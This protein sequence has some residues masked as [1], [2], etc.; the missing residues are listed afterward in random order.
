[1]IYQF[2]TDHEH[3]GIAALLLYAAWRSRDPSRFKITPDVWSQV[4]SFVKASAKRASTLPEFLNSLMPRLRA[5]EL[6]PKWLEV[7]YRGLTA[8]TNRGGHVEFMDAGGERREFA[9]QIFRTADQK[10][11]LRSLRWETQL[12]VLL[13]RDRLEREKPFESQLMGDEQSL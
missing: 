5:G 10:A 3:E 1:M 13:V 7:G 4:T 9:T 8:Y 6:R 2:D 11:V 12:I